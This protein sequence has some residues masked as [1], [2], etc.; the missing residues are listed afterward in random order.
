MLKKIFISIMILAAFCVCGARAFAEVVDKIAIVVNDEM[1]TDGEIQRIIQPIYENYRNMYKGAKI[2]EK[3]EEA[4]QKVVEQMIDDKLILCEAKRLNIEVDEKEIDKKVDDVIKRMGSRDMFERSLAQQ[5]LTT[6]DLRIKYKEQLMTKKLVDQK[7]GSRI[8]ITPVEIA[9]YYAKNSD[10]FV[11]PEE[12]KLWN[13]FIPLKDGAEVQ[14]SASLAKDI[15]KRLKEGCD[16]AGLAKLYSQGPNASEGGLMGYVRK[17][18]LLPE[19]DK[20]VFS[21]KDGEVSDVVQ[22]GVG[23]HIFK[24]ED[25]R[26]GRALLIT[27]VRRDIEEAIFRQKVGE[28]LK[29]WVE[30]LKKNAYIAFK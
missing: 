23:Y 18:Y 13:I 8:M 3:L 5:H 24:L 20:V 11:Q 17:G 21:M 16:F 7:I 30:G 12:I 26:P 15:S 28:K 1:I 4:K 29:G 19:I 14:K 27:E 22:T 6:K 2:I 10:E 25:R 9:N